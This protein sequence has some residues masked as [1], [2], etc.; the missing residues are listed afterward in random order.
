[1][2]PVLTAAQMRA[3][4]RATIE[5]RGVPGIV[6]MENAA[7]G[8][9]RELFRRWPEIERERIVVLCGKGNNGGDGLAVARQL[10]VRRPGASVRTIVLAKPSQLSEDART[11]WTMLRAQDHS[12]EVVASESDWLA[13]RTQIADATLVVDAILGT[14]VSGAARGLAAMAIDDINHRYPHVAVIAVD[15]P[16][17]LNSDTGEILGEPMRADATVTF[18]APKVGQVL[19]PGCDRVGDLSVC[20]IGTAD[21][22]L[23]AIEGSALHLIEAE[24]IQRFTAPRDRSTHKGSYGHVV[25]VGGSRAKPGAILMT[26]YAALRAG[27]GLATVVTASG[28]SGDIVAVAP[29]LMVEPATEQEDGTLGPGAFSG[30]WF[31]GKAVAVLGPGLGNTDANR[32]LARRVY[33]DCP[34]PLVVDADGLAALQGGVPKGR[35]AVTVLTPH[36]GEM[37][38]LLGTDSRAVQSDRLG[39]ARQAARETGAFVV[40]K[41]NRT[42]IA[43][44]NEDVI[45]NPTGTPGMATAGSGDV[46]AGMVAAYLGQFP[47]EPVAE[48]VAAAVYLHGLAG[49]LAARSLGEQGM[50]ATD[51]AR[52]LTEATQAAAA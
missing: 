7:H 43:S 14:G 18:T 3:L 8:V 48:T 5:G 22:L 25:A 24:D 47:E 34:L 51:I 4:D 50:L 1:M 32:E 52:H 28:A 33:T 15:M 2:Q 19:P 13:A 41:G 23:R 30:S 29:E 45:V 46:L 21:S 27:A 17:G 11:N 44:P 10:L 12:P 38:R 37:G 40:L 35:K 36:P 20:R 49:E 9:T 16:S 6:L 26:G 39:A 31:D 42:L